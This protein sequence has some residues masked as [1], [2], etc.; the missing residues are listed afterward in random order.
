[1]GVN[2]SDA[3]ILGIHADRV[4]GEIR[5]VDVATV[6]AIHADRQTIDCQVCVN[7]LL[8]DSLGSAFSEPAPSL[9]DVPLG[10]LRGGGFLVWMPVAVGDSVLLVYT[11]FSTDT[12]R[13][14]DGS[15]QD[16]GFHGAHSQDSPFAIPMF[17]PDAKMLTSPPADPNKLIIGKDG[18]TAQIRISATDIE[19]GAPAGDFV[20]LASK[21]AH[22]LSTI[23][24]VLSSLVAPSGG[25]PVTSPNLPYVPGPVASTLVKSG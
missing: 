23:A 3:E 24:T 10:C 8:H 2:R 17:A 9:S 6:T 18:G 11:D 20:A 5:K 19:L 25:G 22:E 4:K 14:G 1:M 21:V 7:R 13:A 16:P 12:W 15:A